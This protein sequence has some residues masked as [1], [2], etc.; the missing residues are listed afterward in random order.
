MI[1]TGSQVRQGL[2]TWFVLPLRRT[3]IGLGCAGVATLFSACGQTQ[4]L[5]TNQTIQGFV[6]QVVVPSYV[7]VAAGATQ[8]EQ[9]LQTYQQ[10]PTAANLEAARQAWRVA[11]DRWE[12]TECFAF[13]PADSEGFDGAMDTWPIDRQGLKTAAAQPVEQREDSRKGF[14]A[15]E[16]LLFAATEPT[17]SDRQHLVI[18]ATDLTKQAQGLVTRWQQASDQPAYRSVLLSAGSTD[19]AYPT[20]NAAGTE[21][22][23]G[24][25][26]SLSEVASEKIGGPLETQE[27]DRFES[28]VS[29]NTLSDL[30]NNWTGAWNVYRGQRSDGVAAGSLQQRLQQQHPVIA[31]QLDQQFATARQAL[32]AIPEP[33][34][35]NL[36]SPRGK[37]AVLTAQTAIAAVS[38]TLERQVLPLVQ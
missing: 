13:G 34:E 29:R 19:S 21:I 6:D 37:V 35:T 12:Q 23:Q 24:L 3:A 25:V 26:D 27:P 16:E 1:V 9:A 28:F 2:N 20:L 15:I 33:I 7:S 31:Q 32:W 11:R 10:A 22:V 4:A 5:I 17:L 14:H 18:L 30:R 36:A 8:L 38:D